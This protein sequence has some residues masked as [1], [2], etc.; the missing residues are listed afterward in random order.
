MTEDTIRVLIADD[1]ELVRN[2][3]KAALRSR[4]EFNVVGEA[5]D[6]I[7]AVKEAIRL[8]PDLVLMDI[9]M[10]KQNGIEA[11]RDMRSALPGTH[12]LML[13]S[14]ADDKAVMG[15]IVAGASGFMLK[16]VQTPE[17]VQA[18][19]TVA[20]GGSTL[21]PTSA[22]SVIEQI[23]R[24]QVVS[25]E[26]KL[27]QQLTE[28]ERN[29]LELVAEGLTNREIGQR[30]YLSEKTV[31]HHVSD[32]LSKLG[33]ARRAQAATFA[34]RLETER[35][36]SSPR[37]PGS[38]A[39]GG[40][41]GARSTERT[42]SV[43]AETLAVISTYREMPARAYLDASP[44]E[45]SG[46]RTTTSAPASLNARQSAGDASAVVVMTRSPEATVPPSRISVA[47]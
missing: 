40:S 29:V 8:R 22:A 23:R 10:P 31:K 4:P 7:E 2:G 25:Q 9:R 41:V 11:C 26:Q 45:L 15:A 13:T 35:L 19:I 14:F 18:M 20:R 46:V 21:D 28:R 1:H 30:L 6:G 33:L 27:A 38:R 17:L 24:G 36:G 34:V 16:E 47:K 32:I 12:I 39:G 43:R 42:A 37:S 3:L 44:S 5:R